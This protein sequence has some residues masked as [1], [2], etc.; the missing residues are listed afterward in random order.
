MALRQLQLKDCA[1]LYDRQVVQKRWR[2]Y[3]KHVCQITV[4]CLFSYN[5]ELKYCFRFC[6][7]GF[8]SF[9]PGRA[10]FRGMQY[11]MPSAYMYVFSQSQVY[12]VYYF[13]RFLTATFVFHLLKVS[14]AFLL[15]LSQKALLINNGLTCKQLLLLTILAKFSTQRKSRSLCDNTWAL[16]ESRMRDGSYSPKKWMLKKGRPIEAL[17]DPD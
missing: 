14:V 6:Y 11:F 3:Q 8:L 1:T 2:N 9:L 17:L 15:F 5:D 10:G 7:H 16:N 12:T 13:A 4:T